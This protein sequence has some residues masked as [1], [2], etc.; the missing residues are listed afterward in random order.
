MKGFFF[1]LLFIFSTN[2]VATQQLPSKQ[3]RTCGHSQWNFAGKKQPAQKTKARPRLGVAWWVGRHD[4]QQAAAQPRVDLLRLK[5]R[6]A[7]LPLHASYFDLIYQQ[8]Q[9]KNDLHENIWVTGHEKCPCTRVGHSSEISWL[10]FFP[11]KHNFENLLDP[12][13]NIFSHHKI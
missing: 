12:C 8:Q 5:T 9:Q 6:P 10:F 4:R 11:K 13:R 3:S 2:Y 1:L 7:L